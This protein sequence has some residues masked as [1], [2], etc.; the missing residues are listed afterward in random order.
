LLAPL[1]ALG[2]G[3]VYRFGYEHVMGTSLDL[4]VRARDASDAVRAERAMLDEID[5]LC[6]ILS[7]YDPNSEI[8][9]HVRSPSTRCSPELEDVLDAYN[10]WETGTG[11][12]ISCRAAGPDRELNVDALGKA[13]VIDRA[14]TAI[15]RAVP[16][17]K[18]LLLNAGGDL[19][20]WRAPDDALTV[21]DP[22]AAHDNG[23]PL[24]RVAL[25]TGAVA[26]SGTYARGR[27]ILDPRTGLPAPGVVSATVIAR[28]C[29][30]ANALATAICVS[31]PAAGFALVT[32]TTGAEALVVDRDGTLHRSHGFA[33]F[34]R[35]RIE[36][37]VGSP[38]W[39]AGFELT[40]TLTL[41]GL[42][43]KG[44]IRRR[45]RRPYVAVWVEDTSGKVV[46]YLAVWGDRDKYLP[47]LSV[48]WQRAGRDSHLLGSVTRA[49]RDPGR[50]T[51]AW[52][53]FD[54]QGR[55]APMGDYRIVVETNQQHG[56][57]ARQAATIACGPAPARVRLK[58]TANFDPVDV[59][60]GPRITA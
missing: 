30:T 58:A 27:H 11:G 13:Y 16:A 6:S 43:D 17:L 59:Q 19:V 42:A 54:E 18:G 8:S 28:D 39:P 24:A 57:Y 48:F 38:L 37:I 45:P 55:P 47:E 22:F 4:A 20:A 46:R 36:R 26:T 44:G 10:G 31:G 35:P 53:G 15:R 29:V 21:A 2:D 14:A 7:T 12:A 56:D 60:Y 41:T 5:R 9:R 23:A 32:R 50:Y 1:A 40:L 25:T 49:T 34:E 33:G 52:N 51:L 3:D